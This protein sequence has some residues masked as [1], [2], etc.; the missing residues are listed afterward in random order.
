MGVSENIE[1]RTKNI[2]RKGKSESRN[3]REKRQAIW[4]VF[5]VVVWVG[6]APAPTP[7]RSKAL[8]DE[9]HNIGGKISFWRNEFTLRQRLLN[10]GSIG[11]A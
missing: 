10:R 5:F 1:Q 8:F 6:S 4:R 3:A 11:A 2:G 9:M 7:L